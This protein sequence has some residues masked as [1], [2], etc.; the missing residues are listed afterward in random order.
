MGSL[1]GGADPDVDM[2]SLSGGPEGLSGG[3]GGG[4]PGGRG[5][6]V[7]PGIRRVSDRPGFCFFGFL[8]T[9]TPVIVWVGKGFPGGAAAA[10]LICCGTLNRT[11]RGA[12][13]M[14]GCCVGA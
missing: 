6:G 1:S 2:G 7:T 12:G 9:P 5:G 13:G 3:P 11:R 10:V 8:G 14:V 4:G